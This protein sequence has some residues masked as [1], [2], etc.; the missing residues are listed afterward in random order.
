MFRVIFI[1]SSAEEITCQRPFISKKIDLQRIFK[2]RE[3]IVLAL[4]RSSQLSQTAY[5]LKWH[6]QYFSPQKLWRNNVYILGSVRKEHSLFLLLY[7]LKFMSQRTMAENIHK[8]A[9][10]ITKYMT[11]IFP[12]HYF[13][14]I[15]V[16]WCPVTSLIYLVFC[17]TLL[18]RQL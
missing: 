18:W 14:I 11:Y 17:G 13:S 15:R 12:Y 3:Q 8:S 16:N 4:F 10:C 1:T 5:A 9:M 2:K 6:I 7:V